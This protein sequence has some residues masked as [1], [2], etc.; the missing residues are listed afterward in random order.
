MHKEHSKGVEKNHGGRREWGQASDLQA[1]AFGFRQHLQGIIKHWGRFFFFFFLLRDMIFGCGWRCQVKAEGWAKCLLPW[2]NQFIVPATAKE[3]LRNNQAQKQT[4]RGATGFDQWVLS[5]RNCRYIAFFTSHP[6]EK[7]PARQT[8]TQER[9]K[10]DKNKKKKRK[11]HTRGEREERGW[12][13][14]QTL[15]GCKEMQ[16]P[17]GWRRKGGQREFMGKKW[18]AKS[19][20]TGWWMNRKCTKR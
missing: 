6:R 12:K 5:C 13:G 10:R 16:R 3:G 14:E 18:K 11:T 17:L 4:L 20:R 9:A 19:K 15:C 2:T 1:E 8:N 7:D